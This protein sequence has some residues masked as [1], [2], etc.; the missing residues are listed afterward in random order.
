[1]KRMGH[2]E[3]VVHVVNFEMNEFWKRRAFFPMSIDLTGTRRA[4]HRQVEW[5]PGRMP[6]E[7]FP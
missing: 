6:I 2:F 1:M 5:N 7:D 3:K 4:K